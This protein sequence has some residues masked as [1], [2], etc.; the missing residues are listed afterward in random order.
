MIRD[1]SDRAKQDLMNMVA[2]VENEKLCDFTDWVGDCWYS[3]EEWIGLLN[4][5][6][7][8]SNVNEYHKKV[9]DKNNTTLN[10]LEAIF[11]KV[12]AVEAEYH[13]GFCSIISACNSF[14]K[15]LQTLIEII[16]PENGSF[17][18]EEMNALL[19][20]RFT[21][22]QEYLSKYG[23]LRVKKLLEHYKSMDVVS[24]DDKDEFIRVY[25]IYNPEKK[26]KLDNLLSK[27]TEEQ[28]REVKYILYTAD[29]PYRSIYLNELES[30]T[31]GNVSGSDTGVFR[32]FDNTI[33]VDMI[34]EPTNPRG[35]YTTFFHE[36]GHA[37]DYNFYNDGN[38]YSL[39]YRNSEGQ[40]LMDVIYEDV[41]NDIRK[42]IARYTKD[43]NTQEDLLN[44]IMG[45][46]SIDVN[47][48]SKKEKQLLQYIQ[49]YYKKDMHGAQN[50]SC[51]D[52]YGGVTNNI[53]SGEYGHWSDSYWYDRKGNPTG[54]Q[55]TELWAEYY[56]YCMT[57]NE[58]A[59]EN[60]REH[61]PNAAKF[62][63]EMAESMA[64]KR[65]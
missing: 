27:L 19:P 40:S 20:E 61:F 65:G 30:Y 22:Y 31:I 4:L 5:K 62:L 38:F 9:I 42:T 50:E 64:S 59:L 15:I 51:S 6:E 16:S 18:P 46:G 3:F 35:P 33:N 58:E 32:P 43:K 55:A 2:Q 47:K 44:Y 36:S 48:L 41:R 12:Y 25:E 63:D 28:I 53:I 21:E 14:N 24:N 37:L 29:E 11:S 1:F 52:V 54:S 34:K 49:A 7:D 39:T 56:S 8:L 10:E 45:A 57:D 60:L 23:E 26:K 17:S 13:S